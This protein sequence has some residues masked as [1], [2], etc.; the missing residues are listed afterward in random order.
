MEKYRQWKR[1]YQI[2]T[3]V[4]IS[5]FKDFQYMQM[6]TIFDKFCFQKSYDKFKIMFIYI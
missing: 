5:Q 6:I 1:T 2:G 4:S 3:I